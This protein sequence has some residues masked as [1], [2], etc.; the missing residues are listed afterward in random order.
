VGIRK[1]ISGI[2]RGF[3]DRVRARSG[4]K[5]VVDKNIK[6]LGGKPLIAW[7]IEAALK[8]DYIDEVIVS[9]NS[10][11]IIDVAIKN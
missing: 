8:S 1:S 11:N 6:E 7:T 2:E 4:S 5:S 3:N 10:K 9:S